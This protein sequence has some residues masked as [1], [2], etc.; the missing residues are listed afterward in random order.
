MPIYYNLKKDAFFD[1]EIQGKKGLKMPRGDKQHILQ[2]SIPVPS[3]A[4]QQ[5]IVFEIEK[6][7]T[8][9]AELEQQLAEIPKQKE[10]ILKKYL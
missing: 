10:A 3:L 2:Y 1:Y 8:Q 4:E 6:I 9:I 7:E 5:K